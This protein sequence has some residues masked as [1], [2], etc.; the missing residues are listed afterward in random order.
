MGKVGMGA[1]QPGL[2]HEAGVE[3]DEQGRVTRPF[4]KF[5]TVRLG[6]AAQP[7]V[8][9][10]EEVFA[11]GRCALASLADAR[12]AMLPLHFGFFP[13]PSTDRESAETGS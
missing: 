11:R 7:G 5:G 10:G 9:H 6:V 1:H 4:S 2:M 12:I 13:L 8:D 3:M